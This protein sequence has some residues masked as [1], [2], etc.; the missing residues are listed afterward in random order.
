MSKVMVTVD[1]GR[2]PEMSYAMLQSISLLGNAST[3]LAEKC[4]DGITANR[5]RCTELLEGNLSLATAL[6]PHIGYDEAADIAKTAFKEGKTARQVARERKSLP[7]GRLDEVLDPRPM[8]E[9][10]IR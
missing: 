2:L 7:D 4:V 5:E 8:T 6:A 10:G 3:V 9:P 1:I